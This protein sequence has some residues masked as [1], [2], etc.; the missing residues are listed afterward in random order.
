MAKKSAT[1]SD[2]ATTATVAAE[3]LLQED[4]VFLD[5]DVNDLS[6]WEL[7]NPSD[8]DSDS[9]SLHSLENGFLSLYSLKPSSQPKSPII[10]QEIQ[11]LEPCQVQGLVD[12]VN[13]Q[14]DDVKYSPDG[15]YN[16]NQ[17]EVGPVMFSGVAHG[18]ADADADKEEDDD[19]D[20]DED[21]YGLDDELVPWH[22]TGKL[23]RQRMRKLG[24]RVF[25]KMVN[26]KRNP[27]LHVKP[28][29]VRGKH[30]LGIKA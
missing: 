8:A 3:S 22:V 25:A 17:R 28:G 30:G 2:A 19:D 20:D 13:F 21:G 7:I 12:D 14:D 26:S 27:Y 9:E 11:T 4:L 29:C 23:G 5:E 16:R 6:Y 1:Y 24:K 18:L 15:E 10:N